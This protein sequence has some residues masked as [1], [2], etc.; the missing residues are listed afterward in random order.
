MKFIQ[1]ENSIW[2]GNHSFT[3]EQFKLLEPGYIGLPEGYQYR[4]YIPG[5]LHEISGTNVPV[6]KG[7]IEW[8]DGNRYISRINDFLHL[9]KI[10]LEEDEN[11]DNLVKE[12]YFKKL[13]PNQKRALEYPT[14]DELIVALWE[15]VVEKK[16]LDDSGINKLQSKRL[17]IKNKY[18]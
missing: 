10:S 12:E 2:I 15:H 8:E 13:S 9:K 17:K 5:E 1:S 3:L 18:K 14:I 7:S 4:Y 11:I 16:N 6:L